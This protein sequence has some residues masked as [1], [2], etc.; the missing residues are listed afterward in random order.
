MMPEPSSAPEGVDPEVEPEGDP[1]GGPDIDEL[2]DRPDAASMEG[3]INKFMEGL[4][5]QERTGFAQIHRLL[6]LLPVPVQKKTRIM[7]HAEAIE[8]L[9]LPNMTEEEQKRFTPSELVLY[10]H[11]LEYKWTVLSAMRGTSGQPRQNRLARRLDPD[12][13]KRVVH[14]NIY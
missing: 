9:F 1:K 10:K 14:L 2:F 8:G 4:E 11:A 7:T 3:A 6:S 12:S 13:K 5:G